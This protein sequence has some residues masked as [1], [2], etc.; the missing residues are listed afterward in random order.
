MKVLKSKKAKNCF[1]GKN[2]FDLFLSD[3]NTDDF[4]KYLAVAG[5]L[6]L[7]YSTGRPFFTIISRGAYTLKGAIGNR[8]I[9]ILLP[10][11]TGEEI[12]ADIINLIESFPTAD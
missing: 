12:L 10:D 9:R 7:H 3:S 6:D 1:A 2:V 5:V 11:S 4:I 8:N